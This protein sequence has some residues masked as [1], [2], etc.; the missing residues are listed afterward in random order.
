MMCDVFIFFSI[1]TQSMSRLASFSQTLNDCGKKEKPK[2]CMKGR[3]ILDTTN[4]KDE[5]VREWFEHE[6]LNSG[7]KASQSSIL[8]LPLI[9][10]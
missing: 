5:G 10:P 7:S 4:K 8:L 3:G 9:A 1:N 6:T 2:T